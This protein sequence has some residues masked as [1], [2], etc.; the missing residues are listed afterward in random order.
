[1][2]SSN[3][4]QEKRSAHS[5]TIAAAAQAAGRREDEITLVGVSKPALRRHSDAFDAGLSPYPAKNAM[6]ECEASAAKLPACPVG[7]HLRSSA[8][9]TNRPRPHLFTALFVDSV[10]LAERLDRARKIHANGRLRALI[11]AHRR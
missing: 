8:V 11:S 9:Q 7:W 1:M 4:I 2:M 3:I 5:R 10:A 6:Q